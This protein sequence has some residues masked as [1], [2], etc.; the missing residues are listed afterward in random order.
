[1]HQTVSAKLRAA[2]RSEIEAFAAWIEKVSAKPGGT[3]VRDG[4]V[5]DPYW[6]AWN[7]WHGRLMGM[8]RM[9]L[10]AGI[11]RASIEKDK[12]VLPEKV[13]APRPLMAA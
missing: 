6:D 5:D 13:R 4:I 12:E 10:A 11:R 1:M 9:L 7:E 3:G 8:E 2:F